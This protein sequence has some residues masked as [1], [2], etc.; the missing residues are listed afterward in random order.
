[1][2]EGNHAK[3]S[4]ID[5]EEIRPTCSVSIEYVISNKV[6]KHKN[7]QKLKRKQ[8]K[9]Q[10]SQV[11]VQYSGNAFGAKLVETE[12]PAAFFYRIHYDALQQEAKIIVT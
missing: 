11:S 10:K 3:Q 8:S 4:D 12:F 6:Q 5:E 7:K 2:R 9:V 1:M